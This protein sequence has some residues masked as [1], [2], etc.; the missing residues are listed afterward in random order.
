MSNNTF[1]YFNYTQD[2]LLSNCNL[3]DFNQIKPVQN[4]DIW[5]CWQDQN[6]E[7]LYDSDFLNSPSSSLCHG[8]PSSTIVSG[9]SP[10]EEGELNT[11]YFEPLQMSTNTEKPYICSYCSR[12]FSRRHDLQRHSRVHTGIKPYD[13]P[14]CQKSFARSDARGR[15][16]QSDPT[17]SSSIQ[18]LKFIQRKRGNNNTKKNH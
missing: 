1:T 10:I 18:V 14:S 3:I 15:H 4:P 8:S 5:L 6:L 16:F 9:F 7:F 13:C 2:T 11:C 12:A 17:C